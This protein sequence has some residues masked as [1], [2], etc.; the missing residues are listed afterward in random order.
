MPDM[1]L[2]AGDLFL[3]TQTHTLSGTEGS[4]SVRL[5]AKEYQMLEYFMRNPGQILSRDQITQRVWGYE[6]DAEYNNV[7]VYISFLRKKLAYIKTQVAIRAVR[8]AGYIL[9]TEH[10]DS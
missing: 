1:R 5:P 8:G 7:D 9:E 2:C 3:D 6:S 10:H 4:R